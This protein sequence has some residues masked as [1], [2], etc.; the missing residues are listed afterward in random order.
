MHSGPASPQGWA[1]GFTSPLS[2]PRGFSFTFALASL[3]MLNLSGSHHPLLPLVGQHCPVFA[4]Q[5][6]L[7]PLLLYSILG[8]DHQ[9][10]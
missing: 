10:T 8:V 9:N 6:W 7:D 4:A 5:S 2:G 3:L 1:T